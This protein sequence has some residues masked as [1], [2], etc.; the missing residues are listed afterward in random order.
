MYN[1]SGINDCLLIECKSNLENNIDPHNSSWP[2]C[3]LKDNEFYIKPE[4]AGNNH[5]ILLP[6]H[7][8]QD[9]NK[10]LKGIKTILET[11]KIRKVLVCCNCVININTIEERYQ[12]TFYFSQ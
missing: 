2:D 1:A 12:K 3:K 4:K 5:E 11:K 8:Q 7:H 10:L 6:F 9:K